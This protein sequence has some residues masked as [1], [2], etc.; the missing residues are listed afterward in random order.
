MRQLFLMILIGLCLTETVKAQW[1]K[2]VI[3]LPGEIEGKDTIAH[4][5][6]PEVGVFPPRVFK[7][8]SEEQ[9]YW[10][11]V[12]RVKKVLPYAKE[13]A[14]LL[15][16]YEREV[17]TDA[18]NRDKRQYIRKAEEELMKK[19]GPT[20]KKMSINDGR[21]LIKLIDR[22]THRASYEI[23]QELKGSVPA[24]FWQGVARI[25]GNNL[26]T[27]YDPYGEDRQIELIIQYIELGII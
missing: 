10:R 19:Y 24:V 6:L 7:S 11:L 17:P 14:V 27:K 9:Q 5:D 3:I 12:T 15:K 13:A 1:P 20:F 21:V 4:I 26:K 25:F 18:R 22:E 8:K 2:N 23:I 16:K